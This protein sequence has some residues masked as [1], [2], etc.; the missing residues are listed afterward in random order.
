MTAESAVVERAL[1]AVGTTFRLSRL[2]PPTHPAVMEALR[3]VGEALPPL[4]ALGTVEW[5]VG[6]T[7]LHWRGQQLLPRNAQIGEL[8]GLLYARGV[9]ALTVNPG[10]TPDHIQ[11]VFQVAKGTIEHDDATLGQVTLSLGRRTATRLERFRPPTPAE[12]TPALPPQPDAPHPPASPAATQ[13]S[14]PATAHVPA[15]APAPAP[16]PAPAP[17]ADAMVASQ[18]AS[19]MFRLDA[20]PADVEVKRA[21]TALRT[22]TT[23]D[24]QRAAV[25][26]L[27]SLSGT[28]VGLHDVALVAE[29]VT[30]LDRLLS[31]A[32][33]AGLLAAID[34][35]ALAL[36]ERALVQRLVHRLGEPRVPPEERE[37]LVGAV[38]ALAS[39]S[40]ELVVN[41]FRA[42]SGDL[43]A[44]FR[45]AV[46]KAAD[47]AL[48]PLQG[49]LADPNA[50]VVAVAAEFV[51]L[52]GSPQAVTLLLP[53]LRHASEFVREAA[54][55]GLIEAGGRE[56][57][58]PAMPALKDESVAVRAAAARAVAAGG[59]P[60]SSTVLIRRVDQEPDEG[61]QA[62]LLRAIGRLGAKEALEVLARYAEPGG[63]MK[64]RS[65]AVRAAA[66]DGLRHLTRPEARGL[67]EL[68]SKDKEPAVRKA[69]EAALK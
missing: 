54:L 65:P 8:A 59:D 31:T 16:P 23:P 48:E 2:Y 45:A 55:V 62:E 34:T 44:P 14:T 20:L 18:R 27:A 51:G 4:A 57:S 22:A 58:R 61:V 5:K 63:V 46:R 40:M 12:G 52:T 37:A 33:D 15:P 30:A 64:R 36:S 3:Q 1:G 35:A 11:A 29:A 69:A 56:I 19:A 21:L 7:G 53:L 24:E 50:E 41:A 17:S 10:T 25:E 43:R 68:Y 26:K 60:A 39:V 9:R 28:L 32:Q 38:G 49:K 66:V 67:L 42:A 47:R 13:A 6:V